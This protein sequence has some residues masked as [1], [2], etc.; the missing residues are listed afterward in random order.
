MTPEEKEIYGSIFKIALKISKT[1]KYAR[2]A[3]S[4]FRAIREIGDAENED[5]TECWEF[6]KKYIGMDGS[7]EAWDR[8]I[9]EVDDLA[10]S[11]SPFRRRLYNAVINE[12]E[13]KVR[14]GVEK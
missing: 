3:E 6:L 7:I 5:F 9:D 14:E 8:V 1:P 10:R 11:K 2:M 12:I 4:M 13:R